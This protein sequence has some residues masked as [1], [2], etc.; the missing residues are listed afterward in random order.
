MSQPDTGWVSRFVV[1]LCE[2]LLDTEARQ[3]I[4]E[5]ITSLIAAR[6][7]WCAAWLSGF[8]SDIVRSLDP[9]DPWR[10]LTVTKGKALLPDGTPF[11]S[12]VDATDLIH[13]SV[14]DQ[15][16]DLG[17]AALVN[18]LSD[19]SAALLA[20]AAQGWHA[21]LHWLESN[22]VLSAELDR[23]QARDYFKI[24]VTALRWAIHRRRLFQGMED[25][26]VPVTGDAWI[27][28]AELIVAGKPWDESR[29]ARYLSMN[30]IEA[31]NYK[32]FT[33]R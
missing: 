25:Q 3:E 4:D 33:G 8:L 21:T 1:A 29:A 13:A 24:A 31:G 17:L 32:Q 6:P 30:T 22:L 11:G 7:Q 14:M 18:P 5:Q 9:D 19:E 28:R 10:N 26:F 23:D 12:W 20:T 27:N 16:A 15:R 2:P